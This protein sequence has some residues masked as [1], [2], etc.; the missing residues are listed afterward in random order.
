MHN[1]VIE[2]IYR[3]GLNQI[4]FSQH[5]LLDEKSKVVN[6][7]NVFMRDS[8]LKKLTHEKKENHFI[9]FFSVLH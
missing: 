4:R 1:N 9:V 7:T 6:I 5:I 3:C 8:S 2:A